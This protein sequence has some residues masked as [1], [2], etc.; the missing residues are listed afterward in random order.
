[1]LTRWQGWVAAGAVTAIALVLVIT[2]LSDRQMRVWWDLHAMTT[3]TVSGLLVVLI[4]VLLVDQLVRI[5]QLGNRAQAVAAQT[6][7]MMAQATRSV[8]VVSDAI[9]GKG[10]RDSALDE[11]RTYM[12]MLLV[13]APVL[14]DDTVSR[15]F[16]EQAQV[17]G[18]ELAQALTMTAANAGSYSPDRLDKASARLHDASIPLLRPL[19]HDERVAAAGIDTS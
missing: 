11:V 14:I 19:S 6:A 4:T 7:I 5:R 12:V 17:V 10:E 1:V 2:D 15:R 9:K 3:D 16:L 8:K 18:G 13:G